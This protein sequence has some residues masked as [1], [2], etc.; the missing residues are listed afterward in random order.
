[1]SYSQDKIGKT[2]MASFAAGC[3]WGVEEAFR[4]L[5]GVISTSVGYMGGDY[6]KP[7]YEDVCTGQTGHAETVEI[8]YDP[9]IISY[10]ELLA[11]FWNNHDPTTPNRQG[12]DI[13]SQY[14]S[15][16]FYYNEQQKN[17]AM[18]S[19]EKVQSR[20][21]QDIVTQIVPATQFYKAE[22]YHQQYLAKRGRKSC[23]F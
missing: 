14:R 23:R 22:D 18:N 4:C 17:L 19:K 21:R 15:V 7:T 5:N 10:N 2:E 16:I 13:G 9:D 11:V 3:F 12:P 6:E 20:L 8:V 1:M